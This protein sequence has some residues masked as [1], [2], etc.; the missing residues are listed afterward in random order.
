MT[1]A[2]GHE[3]DRDDESQRH[4]G[5]R[6]ET[7]GGTI[8][9]G[10][11]HARDGDRAEEGERSDERQ[12]QRARDAVELAR[13]FDLRVLETI[14]QHQEL[15]PEPRDDAAGAALR[16]VPRALGPIARAGDGVQVQ[17]P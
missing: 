1:I 2:I 14:P 5:P 16:V 12:P 17:A 10:H 9:R 15:A 8:A 7:A 4:R 3:H 6:R 13:V 11:D